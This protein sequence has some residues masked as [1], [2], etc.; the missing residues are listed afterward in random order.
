MAK[1]SGT[2]TQATA[3]AARSLIFAEE[4]ATV[5]RFNVYDVMI[6]CN[7]TPADQSARYEIYRATGGTPAG[8]AVTEFA[9][10][11]ADVAATVAALS[12]VT[13][14]PTGKTFAMDWPQNQRATFRWVAA[15]GSGIWCP[16]TADNGIGVDIAATTSAH[17]PTCTIMWEE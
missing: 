14:E 1:Y 12:D 6:G 5:R 8:S 4:G 16:A 13:T 10:D 3:T 7:A 15:P 17:I 2:G 11:G 9:L